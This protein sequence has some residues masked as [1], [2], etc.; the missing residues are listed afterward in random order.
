[1]IT[2]LQL[3][4]GYGKDKETTKL[5]ENYTWYITPVLNPDGYVYTM[6]STKPDVNLTLFKD[7]NIKM[8]T[9]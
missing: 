4:T 8:I 6:T 7:L 5:I 2:D 3:V 9:F 1:M